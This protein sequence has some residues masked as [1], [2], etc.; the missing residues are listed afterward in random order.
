MKVNTLT[1]EAY[2]A[3]DYLHFNAPVPI[4]RTTVAKLI[5]VKILFRILDSLTPT[6]NKIDNRMMTANE[7]KSGYGAKKLIFIG[8]N[9]RKYVLIR[10]SSNAS[11]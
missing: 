1:F 11:K 7:K 10:L 6:D 5:V 8:N 3:S 4:T 9:S 2:M